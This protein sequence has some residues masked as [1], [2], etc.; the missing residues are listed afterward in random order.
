MPSLAMYTI[1]PP[2]DPAE[3]ENICMDY[4][5]SKYDAEVTLYGRKAKSNRG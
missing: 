3:F 2:T 4:L 5:K 1:T